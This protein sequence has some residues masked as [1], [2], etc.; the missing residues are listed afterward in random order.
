MRTSATTGR[1]IWDLCNNTGQ[2]ITFTTV[3]TRLSLREAQQ[4]FREDPEMKEG[5]LDPSSDDDF[6][7]LFAMRAYKCK[8]GRLSRHQVVSHL[9]ES[10]CRVYRGALRELDHLR[11]TGQVFARRRTPNTLARHFAAR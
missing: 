2:V 6:Y 9:N 7:D 5:H 1:P 3:L 8:D 11:T 10:M 4:K